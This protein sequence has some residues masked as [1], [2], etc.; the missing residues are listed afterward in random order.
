[1]KTKY[2]H[3]YFEQISSLGRFHASYICRNNKTA[4]MLGHID[5]YP[6]WKRYVFE[7]GRN[8]F[9]DASCLRDIIDFM[10]QLK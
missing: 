8:C 4:S 10:E 1:M 9:F 6:D 5:W 2:K 3:I 7:G